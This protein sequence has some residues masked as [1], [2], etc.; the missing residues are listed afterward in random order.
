MIDIEKRIAAW[1]IFGG[2]VVLNFRGSDR[3]RTT[4]GGIIAIF[5]YA[6]VS[7]LSFELFLRFYLQTD[8]EI[9]T[10]EIF[11]EQGHNVYLRENL[12]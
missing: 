8:P 7:F 12:Q 1:D 5:V 11:S 9:K 2:P 3:Y 6:Y 10:Y 4:R